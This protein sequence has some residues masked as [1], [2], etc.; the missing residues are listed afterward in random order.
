MLMYAKLYRYENSSLFMI[1]EDSLG[2]SNFHGSILPI[3]SIDLFIWYTVF[4]TIYFSNKTRS[5]TNG[6]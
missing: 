4:E 2:D 3:S 5:S 1:I 6:K